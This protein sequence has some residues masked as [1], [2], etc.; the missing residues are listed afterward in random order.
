M[1]RDSAESIRSAFTHLDILQNQ[2]SNVDAACVRGLRK[3]DMIEPRPQLRYRGVCYHVK[4][5]LRSANA[6]DVAC[7]LSCHPSRRRVGPNQ[8]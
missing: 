8:Q 4:Q 2:L 5:L 3:T 7:L 1:D 6:A